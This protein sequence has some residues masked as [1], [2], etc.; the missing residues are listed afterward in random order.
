MF[1]NPLILALR[2]LIAGMKPD[3]VLTV[4]EHAAK[5]RIVPSEASSNPGP[6]SN[7][8]APYLTEVMDCL[9]TSHPAN[10]V[11]FIKS[12]QIGGTEVALNA[13]MYFIDQAPGPMMI[14]H[15]TLTSARAWSK[16]KLEPN[17]EVNA[18]IRHKVAEA[19]SRDGGNTST[20]KKFPG[21]FC[22]ITGANSTADLRQKSIKYLIKDDLDD[23]P[24]DVGG[25]GD[26]NKMADARQI[27][28]MASGRYKCLEISTPANKHNSKI[29]KGFEESDQRILKVAC[30]HCGHRQEL[31]FFAT[32]NKTGAG[33]LKFNTSEPYEAV[34]VCEKNGCVIDHHHK[35]SML[36]TAVWEAQQSGP[37]RHPGFKINAL[38]SPM[39]TWDDVVKKYV[40]SKDSPLAYKTFINL[41]LGEPW[42]DKGDAPDYTRLLALR[43]DYLLGFVPAGGLLITC[44]VDVQKDGLYFEVVAWGP[45]LTSWSIDFG[46]IEG[47]TARD[48]VWARLDNQVLG[49]MYRNAWG[50]TMKIDMMAI[51]AGYLPHKVS[52]FVRSRA[53]TIAVRGVPGASAPLLGSPSKTDLKYDGTKRRGSFRVWP[54][55]G[56]QAKTEIY[57]CLRLQGIKEGYPENP[58]GYC[59]F[60]QA[61]DEWFFKQLTSESLV[62]RIRAGRNVTEWEVSGQNHY[63]DCRVYARAAAEHLQVS[64][65]TAETWQKLAATRNTP[66]SALQGDLLSLET[67]LQTV[68]VPAQPSESLPPR[69]LPKGGRPGRRLIGRMAK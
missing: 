60:S 45:G 63:L 55:G 38:Y 66:T 26:P 40:D 2:C 16:E 32:D 48:E 50:Q 30:P 68:P 27:S 42:V 62:T 13:M 1:N 52:A 21:G 54:V 14:V 15:P 34:Y 18:H 17:I 53:R 22:V 46:F 65:Y 23:W 49:A 19:V 25:Q 59:N 47:D 58:L 20:F 29:W 6:W 36:Q 8:Y 35:H 9:S 12:A 11:T 4:S 24:D 7:S 39:V 64:R 44:G 56:W 37:G 41:W 28:Y 43:E 10:R 61:H 31:R 3:P 51:D 69:P 5:Y 33:G 67:Q 57:A